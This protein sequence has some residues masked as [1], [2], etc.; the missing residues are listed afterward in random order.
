MSAQEQEV[1]AEKENDF[2]WELNRE[3]IRPLRSG[4]HVSSLRQLAAR[5]H[6]DI[7]DAQERFQNM[8]SN[9]VNG[10]DPLAEFYEYVCWF[11]ET[12]PSGRQNILYP[13]I[14]K[15]VRRFA[16]DD[17][18]RDEDRMLK[19]WFKLAENCYERCFPIISYAFDKK[20]CTKM[21][22]FYVRWAE[23]YECCGDLESARAKL[24]LGK[25]HLAAPLSEVEDAINALEMRILRASLEQNTDSDNEEP[26][27]ETREVLGRLRG[28]GSGDYAPIIR[29]S[30]GAAGKIIGF[31]KNATFASKKADAFSIFAS[32]LNEDDDF[33]ELFGSLRFEQDI[34]RLTSEENEGEVVKFEAK[35]STAP[36][37]APSAK[38]AFTIFCDDPN[39]QKTTETFYSDVISEIRQPVSTRKTREQPSTKTSELCSLTKKAK[40]KPPKSGVMKL[41]ASCCI[42]S[43]EEVF[44]TSYA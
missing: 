34:G 43:I 32:D 11:E 23:L 21:A 25:R 39:V 14:W 17:R 36:V 2:E 8:Y 37:T 44:A 4:R 29:Q 3:N 13:I 33:V 38:P 41:K 22:K 10:D 20:C 24:D 6:V 27:E 28:L 26:F 19:L 42:D 16:T 30:E 40:F 31:K 12:F 7:K 15:I 1:G 35:R 5:N 9:E 18:Y